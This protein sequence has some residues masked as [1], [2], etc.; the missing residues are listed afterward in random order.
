MVSR[1]SRLFALPAVA[2]ISIAVLI[3]GTSAGN[4][5]EP[6]ASVDAVTSSTA[7][8]AATSTAAAVASAE[9]SSGSA[10]VTALKAPTSAHPFS[11]PEWFPLREPAKIS[12]VKTNCDNKRGPG[13]YHGYWAMDLLT[14]DQVAGD[15]VYAAGAGIFHVGRESHNC[16]A[17]K[18]DTGG[19]W[20]WVDHGGGIVSRYHHLGKITATEGQF[21]TPQTKIGTMGVG[22]VYPCATPYLHF[23][24]RSGGPHGDQINPG[25]LFVCENGEKVSW[26]QALPGGKT[27]WDDL[28]PRKFVTPKT[29]DGCVTPTWTS[30]PA[31]PS[32]SGSASNESV[33]VRWS[34]PAKGVH[35]VAVAFELYHP[36]TSKWSKP[37]Y[38]TLSGDATATTFNGLDNGRD[39]RV[40]VSF[41]NSA[42]SSAWSSYRAFTPAMAPQAPRAP[43][44][45]TPANK[46]I[47]YAWYR[48]EQRGTPVTSYNVAIRRQTSSGFTSWTRTKVSANGTRYDWT[49][50]KPGRTYQVK[51]RAGSAVGPS[52][53][54]K[55]TLVK[56]PR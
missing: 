54:S 52:D 50:L 3:A 51:V 35:N 25:P 41:R 45:V 36:S 20:V 16:G 23:E 6:S 33:H 5:Q 44:W 38:R 46:M 40:K 27:S 17:D 18:G 31:K 30:T 29:G 9:T 43:R 13:K 11:D 39:Y 2:T 4:A 7:T 24:V 26:P 8:S 48:A 28:D 47:R 49:S 14:P 37:T 10:E 21:V 1:R 19:T 15:P 56:V 12:C 53:Y 55:R 34:A 32:T 42:G 22:T